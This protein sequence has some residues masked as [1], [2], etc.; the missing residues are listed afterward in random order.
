M[1]VKLH[2]RGFFISTAVTLALILAAIGVQAYVGVSQER[3]TV[4]TTGAG[5]ERTVEYAVALA[6]RAG[7]DVEISREAMP[8]EAAVETAVRAGKVDVGLVPAGDGWRLLGRTDREEAAA[9]WIGAAVRQLALERNAA[10]AGTSVAELERGAAVEYR[11]LAEGDTP[12][13]VVR[14]STFV[15]GF[16]FYLAAV[17]F[18]VAISTS[19]V[20]EKQNRIV[21]IIAS[22]IPLRSLLIGKVVGNSLLALAQL[23]LFLGGGLAGLAAMGQADV[24]DQVSAGTGW[25]AVFFVFGF[26]LLACVYAATGAISTRTA[27]IQ[28][29]TTP[30]S[31]TVAV[32]FI[33]GISV[34]GAVQTVLSFVPLT[35]AIT[36]PAR[37]VAGE[38]SWWE[39]ALSLAITAMTAGVVILVGERIYRRALMQT[40]RRLSFRQALRLPE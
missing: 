4:A 7:Q 10:E 30:V 20:E 2:D 26:A 37:I 22:A 13:M 16:L 19:V 24:L 23:V 1:V 3:I 6:D 31:A 15:F 36:M 14:I 25:F 11:L 8:D 40:G 17:L 29:T 32:V 9:V 34:S 12:E 38:T 18:G 28:A 33:A 35:S 39:P 27:D 21:E 5:S